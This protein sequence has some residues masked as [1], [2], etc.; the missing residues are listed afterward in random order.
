MTKQ[1]ATI[2][3]YVSSF[4]AD[5]QLIL[6]QIRQT[7]HDVVPTADESISYQMPTM[8]VDGRLLIHFAA[9]KNYISLYPTPTGDQAF[10]EEIAPYRAAKSTVR[11]PLRK[12]IPDDLIRRLVALRVAQQ[13]VHTE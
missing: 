1:F 11:F 13:V 10:E 12:P 3:D 7:V 6:Q 4:P 2:D 5:V 8:T 9:W